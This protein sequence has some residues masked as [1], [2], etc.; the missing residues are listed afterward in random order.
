MLGTFG[1]SQLKRRVSL[2]VHTKIPATMTVRCTNLLDDNGALY[3][4]S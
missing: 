1:F 3:E 2:T 4:R